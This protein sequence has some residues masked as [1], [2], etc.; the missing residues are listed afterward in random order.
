MGVVDSVGHKELAG[1]RAQEVPGVV[2]V[3]NALVV[4][5]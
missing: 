5:P 1:V 3:E 2:G 4:A